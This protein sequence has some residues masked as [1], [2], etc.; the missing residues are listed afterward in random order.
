MQALKN[1]GVFCENLLSKINWNS[2]K[3]FSADYW[4]IYLLFLAFVWREKCAGIISWFMTKILF[5][6]GKPNVSVCILT[7]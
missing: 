7:C 5:S 1:V 4:E 2:P 3:E 6:S